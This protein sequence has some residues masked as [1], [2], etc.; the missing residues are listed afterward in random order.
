[1]YSVVGCDAASFLLN[2]LGNDRVQKY[3]IDLC[4]FPSHGPSLVPS[5]TSHSIFP[6]YRLSRAILLDER[7]S[8]LATV[9]YCFNPASVFYAAAYTEG[10]FAAL[11]FVGMWYLHQPQHYWRGIACFTLATAA[12][13]N[14]LLNGW[15]VAH[16]GLRRL[17]KAWPRQKV[18]MGPGILSD[19][20]AL[21]VISVP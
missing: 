11:S 9:L 3:P 16:W 21:S 4:G 2:D 1:M 13:S 5:R 17:L 18:S 12:R 20:H 14:G 7:L 6:G 10:L 19:N 8:A 15:F